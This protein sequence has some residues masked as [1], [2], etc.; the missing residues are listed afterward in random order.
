MQNSREISE[1][2]SADSRLISSQSGFR[3]EGDLEALSPGFKA[4][5]CMPRRYTQEGENVSP[6]LTWCNFPAG[7]PAGADLTEVQN[8]MKNHVLAEATFIGIY[9]RFGVLE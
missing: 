6:P 5:E 4:G 7:I 8:A 9:E 3:P 1:I 2:E